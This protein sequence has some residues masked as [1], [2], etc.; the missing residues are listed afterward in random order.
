MSLSNLPNS[1]HIGV[2][3]PQ[4]H[5]GP[6]SNTLPA[7]F[8]TWAGSLFVLM[9]LLAGGVRIGKHLCYRHRKHQTLVLAQKRATLEQIWIREIP[10]PQNPPFQDRPW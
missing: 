7:P 6:N 3:A 5:M 1:Q 4:Y 8:L 2:V 10:Q 9:F